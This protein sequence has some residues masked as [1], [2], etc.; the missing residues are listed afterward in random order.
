[1]VQLEIALAAHAELAS[2][3]LQRAFDSLRQ[4]RGYSV[5][6]TY[7]GWDV[8]WKELVDTAIYKRG[9]DVSETGSTWI[10]SL[11]AMNALRPFTKREIDQL[12]G[13]STFLPLS[14]Q[15]V[16][17]VGDPQVWAIPYMTEARV[18]YYW[19]DML[20]QASL[21][22]QTAFQSPEQFEETCTRLQRVI[23]TPWAD[24]TDPNSH[25]ILYTAASWIWAKGG[26]FLSPDGRR[27]LVDKPAARAGLRSYLSLYRFMPQ[28]GQPVHDDRIFDL[29]MNRQIAA[30]MSGPWLPINLKD[31]GLSADRLSQIGIALPPGPPFVGGMY[32]IV[33]QHTR[34][35][36]EA[37]DLISRLTR[38][39][40]QTEFCPLA[41]LLPASREAWTTGAFAADQNYRVLSQAM[42]SGRSCLNIPLWGM[43]EDKLTLAFG[44]IWADLIERPD[45]NIDAILAR[46][47]EPLAQRLNMTLAQ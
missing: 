22:P 18:I 5:H 31:R 37:I 8:I 34:H 3:Y 26:D 28:T 27:V 13:P 47:L 10:A 45:Q 33:W 14:W 29:F 40:F 15:G 42:Q 44:Q 25:N 24:V 38:P 43:V 2:S 7:L 32:L 41:G 11:V 6:A 12:G 23:S 20:E 9:A 1:M 30:L 35:A 4:E 36:D 17:L 39:Q 21:D 46:H 19:R 16:S